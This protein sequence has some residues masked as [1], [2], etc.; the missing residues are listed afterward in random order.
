ML[1]QIKFLDGTV[2]RG[3]TPDKAN[4]LWNERKDAVSMNEEGYPFERH[5]DNRKL[6]VRLGLRCG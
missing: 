6:Q 2:V 1:Y 5:P 3:L 4:D